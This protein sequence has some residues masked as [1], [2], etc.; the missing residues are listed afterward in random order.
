MMI[1]IISQTKLYLKRNNGRKKRWLWM[2]GAKVIFIF[3]RLFFLFLELKVDVF[4]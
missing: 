1:I 3:K 4:I 2:F